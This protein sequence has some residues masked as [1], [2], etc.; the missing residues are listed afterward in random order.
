MK[1][2][3]FDLDGTLLDT[4][5][6]IADSCNAAL[7][8]HNF[9]SHAVSSYRYFVGDGVHVLLTRTVPPSHLNAETLAS[10]AAAYREEYHRRWN[11]T[12]K[13]YPGIADL[14]D[15]L[16]RR[17]TLMAVLSNKPDEFTRRCVT[18]FLP[19]WTFSI[20]LGASE[21]F[22]TKPNPASALHIASTLKLPPGQFVYLGDTSTDMQT[23]VAAGMLPVGVLWGFRPAEE[24]KAAGARYLI[25]HPRELLRL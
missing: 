7:A 18:E 23:S 17:G 20:V 4:L 25:A 5:Q 2:V 19:R 6:D 10:V 1:A 11:A 14:L 24:L 15:E 22:P 9:P 16:M 8:R 21:A 12:T 3:L 13:P